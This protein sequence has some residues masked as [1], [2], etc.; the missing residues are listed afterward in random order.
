MY[1]QEYDGGDDIVQCPYDKFHR[2]LRHRMTKHMWK[3]HRRDIKSSN[4][5]P[6]NFVRCS[7]S[8]NSRSNYH[9]NRSNSHNN[10]TNPHNNRS[11]PSKFRGKGYNPLI[12]NNSSSSKKNSSSGDQ[13][14]NSCAR[15]GTSRIRSPPANVSTNDSPLLRSLLHPKRLSKIIIH[16]DK[17]IKK[18]RI[19]TIIIEDTQPEIIEIPDTQPQIIE[20]PDTQPQIIEIPD[21]QPQIIEIPDSQ[22]QKIEI[23]DT[24]PQIIEIPDT[25]PQTIEILDTQ[26]I[27]TI[28]IP[29]TQQIL[30]SVLE[31]NF[32]MGNEFGDISLLNFFDNKSGESENVDVDVNDYRD[33]NLDHYSEVVINDLYNQCQL[34]NND[35]G[36][37][38]DDYG[39]L[40]P[41]FDENLLNSQ[42]L[43]D[44][45]Q[46]RDNNYD[47][48]RL[49]D[50][51]NKRSQMRDNDQGYQ[52]LVEVG[53]DLEDVDDIGVMVNCI[54]L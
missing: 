54:T 52:R 9:N 24:Q 51:E 20:I 48:Q 42:Q 35:Q 44:R 37:H 33:E 39:D 28:E 31:N 18:P 6:N 10:R 25:Q 45:H 53:E 50:V 14:C 46:M 47:C 15:P 1:F 7:N 5:D 40:V 16:S 32:G 34:G 4:N 3:C 43:I 13:E 22:P 38:D 23:P 11:N 2:C 19:E 26:P 27:E 29:N 21:T 41:T 8:P 30:D 12:K 36:V 49:V 17:L